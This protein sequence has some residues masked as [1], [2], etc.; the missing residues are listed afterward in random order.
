MEVWCSRKMKVL[1]V[2]YEFPPLGGGASNATWFIGKS[3]VK[4]GHE[5]SV[6][7]SGWGALKG[8]SHE[9]GME[10]DRLST[11]RRQKDCSGN[12][13]KLLFLLIALVKLHKIVKDKQTQGIIVFFTIPCGPLGWVAKRIYGIPY[14]ISLRGGDVPGL[15]PEISWIHSLIKPVRRASL[16]S[17]IAVVANSE[18]LRRLSEEFDPISVRVISNGVDTEFFYP[19]PPR[20]VRNFRFLFVGRFQSQKNLFFLLENIVQISD[21]CSNPF[22]VMLVGDGP[23]KDEVIKHAGILGIGNRFEW[24]GWCDKLELRKLYQNADCFINPSLYEGMPNTVLEAMACGLPVIASNVIGNLDLVCNG[25]T[26][27]LFDLERPDDFQKFLIDLLEDPD[28]AKRFGI[29]GRQRVE[30]E[31]SWLRVANEYVELFERE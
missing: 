9:S 30:A 3:L 18:G 23:L 14:V 2:N 15:V 11:G 16:K 26:G 22:T 8:W 31:F 7:T 13:E 29:A 10:I 28:K 19:L 25:E 17:A 27:Y 20:E 12:M 6:L 5:V 24:V 21:K 1:L 4:L